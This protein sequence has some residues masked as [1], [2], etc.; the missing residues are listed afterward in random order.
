M[1]DFSVDVVTR[2]ICPPPCPLL[3]SFT[4]AWWLTAS[5]GID[6]CKAT[7]RIPIQIN[8]IFCH[9]SLNPDTTYENHK[10]SFVV[11]HCQRN[12]HLRGTLCLC[13]HSVLLSHARRFLLLNLPVCLEGSR[14]D[15]AQYLWHIS[16]LQSRH[17]SARNFHSAFP[18]V[19]WTMGRGWDMVFTLSCLHSFPQW[20]C[21]SKSISLHINSPHCHFSFTQLNVQFNPV[22]RLTLMNR[23]I[24]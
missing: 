11:N 19:T 6:L 3:H 7:R 21:K 13:F 23:F 1:A 17:A 10:L 15:S 22:W 18:T 24:E 4:I 12:G 9:M 20:S 2:K 5:F 16:A 8:V 14:A